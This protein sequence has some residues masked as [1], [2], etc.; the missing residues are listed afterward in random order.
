MCRLFSVCLLLM[1]FLSSCEKE[2]QLDLGGGE[3]KPVVDGFIENGQVP[4]VVLTK[5]LSY[6]SK[7]DLS[8][9]EGAFIHDAVIRVSDGSREVL[10]REY[11]L[12]TGFNSNKYYFYTVDTANPASF[13]F[14]GQTDKYYT[15]N[16]DWQGKRY[17]STT[18]IPNVGPLDSIWALPPAIPPQKVPAAMLLY[19]R[20]TDPD[21]LGNNVRYFTRRNGGIYL[22]GPNSVYEDAVVNATTFNLNLAAGTSQRNVFTDSTGFFFRG[23]TVTVRW[24]AID[25]SVYDFWSTFEFAAG[26]VG[27]PFSTPTSVLTNIRGGA[28][29]VWAGYGATYKTL[30]IPK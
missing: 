6:F 8:T 22:P 17:T 24:C 16:I 11:S 27:N 12:D 26:T 7:V 13:S 23:D 4:I 30:V 10:L 21:T 9:L 28:L 15:L 29:G 14:R 18:K 19:V 1:I 20:Y 2:V 5:S 25:R 3:T